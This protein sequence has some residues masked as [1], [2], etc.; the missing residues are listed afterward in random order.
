MQW[1]IADPNNIA[2]DGETNYRNYQAQ[3]FDIKFIYLFGGRL[4]VVKLAPIGVFVAASI[5]ALGILF[6]TLESR[7]VWNN[8]LP[9][10]VI[11]FSYCWFITITM[12]TQ[13]ATQDPG[14]LP[15]NVHMP[16]DLRL[17]K[18]NNPP[19]YFSAIS[20]PTYRDSHHGVAVK[21]CPTCHIWRPPRTSHCGVCNA[22]VVNQDHHCIY[23]NNCV[24]LRN[25][26]YFLWFVLGA[27]VSA[28]MLVVECFVHLF[29]YRIVDSEIT[30]FRQSI[31][32]DPGTFVLLLLSLLSLLYPCLVLMVHLVLTL[33]N[34]STREYLN[35]VRHDDNW[36]NVFD[37]GSILKNLYI[38]WIG[39]S[40]GNSYV[41]LREH[42]TPGDVRMESIEPLE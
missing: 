25:Y 27:T 16:Y 17:E 5:I 11:V 19:E 9:A 13:V 21:Y 34:L 28:I 39:K 30:S 23:I 36:K 24:G 4:R 33:R 41:R 40:R 2:I 26:K 42:Y 14:I 7:W 15:R 20:L 12:F 1:I 22:C 18:L 6:W 8:I 38:N 37:T 3:K 31:S 32:Q 35:N 29:F 10:L